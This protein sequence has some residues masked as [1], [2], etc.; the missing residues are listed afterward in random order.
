M[1]DDEL[2]LV[3]PFEGNSQFVIA[4][5]L[6]DQWNSIPA[7]ATVAFSLSR[8]E[9]DRFFF[10]NVHLAIAVDNLQ[11]SVIALSNAQTADAIKAMDNSVRYL[12]EFKGNL[13]ALMAAIMGAAA[14]VESRHA[15]KL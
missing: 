5:E 1:T 13:R 8:E 15:S 7:A 14:T 2:P 6:I 9:L 10:L 12:N 3:F 4:N 11:A